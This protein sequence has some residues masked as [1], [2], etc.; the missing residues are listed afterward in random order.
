MIPS[1]RFAQLLEPY[2]DVDLSFQRIPEDVIEDYVST[3]LEPVHGDLH[4]DSLLADK[5]PLSKLGR[6]L[7]V[8]QSL[9]PTMTADELRRK[10]IQDAGSNIALLKLRLEAC[11]DAKMRCAIETG[12]LRGL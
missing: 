10:I 5:P 11:D 8:S 9:I 6:M 2:D 12:F 4:L 7:V 3:E 1:N